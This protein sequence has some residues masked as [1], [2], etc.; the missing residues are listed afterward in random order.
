MEN[1]ILHYLSLKNQYQKSSLLWELYR[2]PHDTASKRCP[3]RFELIA[4]RGSVAR[5]SEPSWYP[6]HGV[7]GF[8]LW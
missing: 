1:C 6:A 2:R 4:F 7:R 3:I 5:V 8:P